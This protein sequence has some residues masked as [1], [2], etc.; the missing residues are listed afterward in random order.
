MKKFKGFDEVVKYC[1][2]ENKKADRKDAESDVF[3]H[4]DKV[5]NEMEDK[6]GV[7]SASRKESVLLL[8]FDELEREIYRAYWKGLEKGRALGGLEPLFKGEV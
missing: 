4:V 3:W 2:R 5:V 7:K 8:S 6:K 1:K